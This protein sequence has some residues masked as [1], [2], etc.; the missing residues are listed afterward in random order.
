MEF[1]PG[2]KQEPL[3]QE[4]LLTSEARLAEQALLLFLLGRYAC[5]QLL[6]CDVWQCSLEW[7]NLQ[8]L[9]LRRQTVLDALRH[10]HVLCR[11]ELPVTQALADFRIEPETRLVLT[12][13]GAAQALQGLAAH[14]GGHGGADGEV[15]K[16]RKGRPKPHWDRHARSLYYGE[17]LILHFRRD[18]PN[19]MHILEAFQELHW[20]PRLDDPLPPRGGVDR[21]ERLHDAVKNLN[22]GQSPLRLSFVMEADGRGVRWLVI[23]A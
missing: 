10:G 16:K 20:P 3:V 8:P 11:P 5:A 18:A 2:P 22:L 12:E 7:R 15:A 17:T 6:G 14:R 13:A 9:G 21:R 1:L 4:L 23:E 19:R